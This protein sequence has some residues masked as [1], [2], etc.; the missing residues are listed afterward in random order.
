M[1]SRKARLILTGVLVLA[2]GIGIVSANAGSSEG[3]D[4]SRA[5]IGTVVTEP[6]PA[7][8]G[9]APAELA[10]GGEQPAP[11]GSA[12]G[13]W[14]RPAADQ[15]SPSLLWVF[16]PS[17]NSGYQKEYQPIGVNGPV[18][19]EHPFTYGST[20]S[21]VRLSFL[22]ITSGTSHENLTSLRYDTS[23]G[24]LLLDR[25]GRSE[26]WYGCTSSGMPAQAA[27]LC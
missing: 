23:E 3:D 18:E 10:Q 14:W 24:V 9:P 22:S 7:P 21:G 19:Y 17:T 15:I 16:D 27:A 20:G 11:A 13:V 5:A 25:D 12:P 8:V 26:S 2:G 6:A 1:P 4:S